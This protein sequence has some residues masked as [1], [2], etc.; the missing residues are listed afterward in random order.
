MLAL[1]YGMLTLASFLTAELIFQR[2][3][4]SKLKIVLSLQSIENAKKN[5]LKVANKI[6]KKDSSSLIINIGKRTINL[7]HSRFGWVLA[8]ISVAISNLS[9]LAIS[10]GLILHHWI[11][12]KKIF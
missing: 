9:L 6:T 1:E 7:H 11:R 8:G 2:S 10:A 4:L 3:K 12:E 5:I